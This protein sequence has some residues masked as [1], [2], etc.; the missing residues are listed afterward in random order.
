MTRTAASEP[1]RFK[2]QREA[3]VY[4]P[5]HEGEVL[6]WDFAMEE[7]RDHMG[8]TTSLQAAAVR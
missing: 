5:Q 3:R 1:Q 2:F 7:T 4:E 8:R 6:I